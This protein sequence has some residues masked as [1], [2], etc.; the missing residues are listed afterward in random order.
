M[1]GVNPADETTVPFPD[2]VPVPTDVHPAPVQ[3][4][5]ALADGPLTQNVTVPPA[6]APEELANAEVIEAALIAVPAVPDAGA[7]TDTVGDAFAT[8][9]ELIPAPQVLA[10][11]PFSESP[12]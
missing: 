5:G 12:P 3:V 7:D 11:A 4:A 9:V 2:T 8:T 10:E 1:L 6:F